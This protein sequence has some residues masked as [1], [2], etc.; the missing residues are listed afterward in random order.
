M[1][2]GELHR[3][4]EPWARWLYQTAELN[5]LRPRVTSTYRSIAKQEQLYRDY[6]AGRSKL[7]AAR[8][9]YSL[10]NYGLAFDMVSED[11]KW[12]GEVWESVGGRW[13]GRFGDPV[14]FDTGQKISG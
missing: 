14:H 5:G 7:P 12:L 11:N 4:F 3:D 10:H 8:P 13:G 2:F 1:S 6:L 9:G